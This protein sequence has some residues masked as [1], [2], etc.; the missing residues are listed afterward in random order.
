MNMELPSDET[1]GRFEKTIGPTLTTVLIWTMFVAVMVVS[2]GFII[3]GLKG[4]AGSV[5][6]FVPGWGAWVDWLFRI[7]AVAVYAFGFWV[8]W[9]RI[10]RR[11]RETDAKILSA[12]EA[13]DER[14]TAHENQLNEIRYLTDHFEK[15]LGG[16]LQEVLTQ[17]FMAQRGFAVGGVQRHMVPLPVPNPMN[18]Q[19]RTKLEKAKALLREAAAA[20]LSI[21]EPGSDFHK[22]TNQ[23]WL[24]S[25]IHRLVGTI[26]QFPAY[27]DFGTFRDAF[28]HK[29]RQRGQKV[30]TRGRVLATGQF[31]NELAN[32]LVLEDVTEEGELP[33][34]FRAFLGD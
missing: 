8:V 7:L 11:A 1:L 6:P 4:A 26:L 15:I 30:D 13:L 21:E 14:L 12:V 10:N 33:D 16:P 24:E 25:S 5:R 18:E 17:K 27:R 29:A 3:G 2:V 22:L 31:L 32:K 34:S 28:N 9:R 19:E 23:A 20:A